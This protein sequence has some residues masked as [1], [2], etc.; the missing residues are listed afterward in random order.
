[1]LDPVEPTDLS[2]SHTQVK[3]YIWE[4]RKFFPKEKKLRSAESLEINQTRRRTF[5]TLL[6]M[7][8]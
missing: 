6:Y 8:M 5:C 2:M 1:M 4:L 3:Q 7:E